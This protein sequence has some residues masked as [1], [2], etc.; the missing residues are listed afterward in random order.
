[1][2][3]MDESKSYVEGGITFGSSCLQMFIVWGPASGE[4]E[5][6]DLPIPFF[7]LCRKTYWRF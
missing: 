2:A 5:V 3:F 6:E 4:S 1:M 7:P